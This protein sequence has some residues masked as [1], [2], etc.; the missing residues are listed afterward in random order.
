MVAA[1]KDSAINTCTMTDNIMLIVT[2]TYF[3]L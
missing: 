1:P 3:S 2:E